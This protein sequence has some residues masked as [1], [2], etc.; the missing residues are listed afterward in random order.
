MKEKWRED[1]KIALG[2]Y[3]YINKNYYL[4]DEAIAEFA[5]EYLVEFLKDSLS[6]CLNVS[7][8][9]CDIWYLESHRGCLELM[10]A[11]RD[12]TG[13]SVFDKIPNQLKPEYN[14]DELW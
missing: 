2:Q 6:A 3:R 14:T 10:E 5:L 11:I 1:A 12:I 13:I 7:E 8:G 9:F 4:S